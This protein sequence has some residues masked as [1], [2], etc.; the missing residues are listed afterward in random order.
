[1]DASLFYLLRHRHVVV[2]PLQ[3][4]DEMT[5]A[6]VGFSIGLINRDSTETQCTPM[7]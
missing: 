6:K 2:T 5:K 4:P 3:T 1:M 7:S